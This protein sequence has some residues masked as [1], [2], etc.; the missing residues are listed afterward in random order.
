MLPSFNLV[1]KRHY[2]ELP[3]LVVGENHSIVMKL[4]F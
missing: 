4:Y 3:D 2:R 1:G